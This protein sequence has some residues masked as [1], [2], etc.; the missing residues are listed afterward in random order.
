M[1]VR[2]VRALAAFRQF[3]DMWAS[4]KLSNKQKWTCTAH[5][6]CPFSYT[7]E[8]WTWTEVQMGRLEVTHSN[9][10]CRIVGVKLTD[11]HR[12]ETVSCRRWLRGITQ[13]EAESQEYWRLFWDVQLCNPGMC[14]SEIL[15]CHEEGS[16]GGTTF[17]D[18][19]KFPA[20]TQ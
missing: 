17:R 18:F 19:L 11:R 6:F 1:D 16:G 15:G 13:V 7:A 5:L 10:L 4:P 14:S 8:T 2:N 3:Q 20:H 9:C 12:L